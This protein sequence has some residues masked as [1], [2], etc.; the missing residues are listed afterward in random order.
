MPK[1][2]ITL[3]TLEQATKS[4]SHVGYELI[5]GAAKLLPLVMAIPANA[6]TNKTQDDNPNMGAF[7]GTTFGLSVVVFAAIELYL[8]YKNRQSA[9]VRNFNRVSNDKFPPEVSAAILGYLPAEDTVL[10]NAGAVERCR[11]APEVEAREVVEFLRQEEAA[12]C[13][14]NCLKRVFSF[15]G[16]AAAGGADDHPE[17]HDPMLQHVGP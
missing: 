5:T 7:L 8:Y 9:I 17:E 4:L 2:F 16:G 6:Q 1:S 13:S 11:N 15:F 10:G 12:R 3:P 14:C